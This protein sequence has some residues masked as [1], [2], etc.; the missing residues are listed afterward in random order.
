MQYACQ[1]A[2]YGGAVKG[3]KQF[4]LQ[5]VQDVESLLGLFVSLS[6]F[7]NTTADAF[8]DEERSS[9]TCVPRNLKEAPVRN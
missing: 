6:L 7:S 1:D 2:L 4:Y 3:H 5:V 8:D 9:A